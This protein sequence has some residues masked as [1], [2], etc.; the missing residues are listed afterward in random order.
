MDAR[1]VNRTKKAAADATERLQESSSIATEGFRDYQLKILAATHENIIGMFE[2]I[3]DVVKAR[4]LPELF[5]ISTTHSQRQLSRMTEQAQEIAGV[6]QKM[7]T[8]STRPFG[9]AFDT[10]A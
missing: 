3:E 2:Y 6:A 10:G 4:S 1:T 5:Q 9:R 7:A 8:E